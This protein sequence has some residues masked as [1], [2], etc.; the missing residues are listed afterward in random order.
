MT[1]SGKSSQGGDTV[2]WN[3]RIFGAD[4]DLNPQRNG[5]LPDVSPVIP[6]PRLRGSYL[7]EGGR[8]DGWLP[9]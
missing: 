4:M 6:A 7:H 9:A 5:K 2:L 8:R 1:S 3:L